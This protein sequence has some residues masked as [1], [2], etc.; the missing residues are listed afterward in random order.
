LRQQFTRHKP[1]AKFE[2]E[3]D[4]I[5]LGCY[6]WAQQH[7]RRSVWRQYRNQVD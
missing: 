4:E 1:R 6:D 3:I 2:F 5:V 7:G